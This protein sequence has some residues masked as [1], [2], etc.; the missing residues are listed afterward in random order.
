MDSDIPAG[1]SANFTEEEKES[2]R[3]G[4]NRFRQLVKENFKPTSKQEEFI[5]ERLDHLSEAVDN[6]NRF[7]WRGVALSTLISIA[8]NLTVDTERG[9][10]L[11]T[12]FQQ[13]F[14]EAT[15]YLK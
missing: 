3:R 11:Y 6:L 9:R 5:N 1:E 10:F 13:A 14:R 15:K 12:L 7:D 8:V 4:I 2:V